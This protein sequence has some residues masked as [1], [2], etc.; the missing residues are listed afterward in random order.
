MYG[1]N[2]LGGVNF[3]ESDNGGEID[4]RLNSYGYYGKGLR[5]AVSLSRPESYGLVAMGFGRL[6]VTDYRAV[7]FYVRGEYGEEDAVVYLNDG[8][9]RASVEISQ[10]IQVTKMWRK[11]AIPLSAFK[12]KGIDLSRLSQLIL[13]W[14]DKV[15]SQQIIYFDNF[16]FE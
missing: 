14:E 7:S 6:D 3:E 1:I 4:V 9:C 8:K 5:V 15:I 13:A 10:F 12:K 2:A 11:V 16:I